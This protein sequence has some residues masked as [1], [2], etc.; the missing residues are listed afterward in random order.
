MSAWGNCAAGVHGGLFASP[1]FVFNLPHFGGKNN[2]PQVLVA[3]FPTDN[4]LMFI[5][6]KPFSQSCPE[7]TTCLLMGSQAARSTLHF[8]D[9]TVRQRWL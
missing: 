1:H 9:P 7:A 8:N 2:L 5:L 4:D 3:A 6:G